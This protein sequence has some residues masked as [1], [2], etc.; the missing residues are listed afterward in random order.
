[1]ALK[2]GDAETALSMIEGVGINWYAPKYSYEVFKRELTH[3]SPGWP[4][5]T[6]GGLGHLAPLYDLWKEYNS[7][8]EKI[9]RNSTDYDEETRVIE[10]YYRVSLYEYRKRVS[11]IADVLER[12]TAVLKETN[13]LMKTG[14][15]TQV[16]SET[17][18]RPTA[19]ESIMLIIL[20]LLLL[21]LVIGVLYTRRR[22]SYS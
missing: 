15:T 4:K 20:T 13:S 8:S 17:P 10:M 14:V 3:K 18:S 21:V 12:A 6:W 11:E 7:I 1:D 9:A 5:V 2:Q 19:V 22:G 16:T